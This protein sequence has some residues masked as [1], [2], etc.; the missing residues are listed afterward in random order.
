MAS[1]HR[2]EEKNKK[3]HDH[4]VFEL[5]GQQYSVHIRIHKPVFSLLHKG[6]VYFL[7]IDRLTFLSLF[8]PS[9]SRELTLS[10]L[11][12]FHK[13]FL[14]VEGFNFIRDGCPSE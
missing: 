4:V 6:F 7:N 8:W 2:P 1:K 5:H 9:A 10:K 3:L 11:V 14:T 13:Q 12:L